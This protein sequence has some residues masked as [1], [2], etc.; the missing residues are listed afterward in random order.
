[1]STRETATKLIVARVVRDRLSA[2]DKG[3][4]EQA[5][6]DFDVPG[7]RDIGVIG[8]EQIGSVQL[9]KG[10]EAWTVTDPDALLKWVKA[11][12]SDEVVTVEQVRS[13]YVTALL[14]RAKAEGNAVDPFTGELIPGIDCRTTPPTLTVK[15]SEDAAQ[16]IAQAF[17]DGRLSL[18]DLTPPL[19]IEGG[20]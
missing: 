19:A 4:R 1:V 13:S 3:L 2:A 8:D 6:A 12:V 10:R 9:T 17:A 20:E 11:N 14:A 16:T 7:V 15:P 18:E 5:R